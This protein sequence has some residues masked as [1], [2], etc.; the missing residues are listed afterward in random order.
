MREIS[1][2]RKNSTVPVAV[3]GFGTVGRSVAR[4]LDGNAGHNLQ[5]S[6]I[7]TR[8]GAAKRPPWL[9]PSVRFTDSF[10]EVLASGA[11]I[12]VELIG[13]VNPAR[14]WIEKALH[15][16][17]SVVTANKEVIA[18][19]GEHLAEL[20]RSR[21]SQLRF[22]GA[23][24]GVIPVIAA[25]Q[26]G[27]A[28]DRAARIAGILNGTCNHV[29][30]RMETEELPFEDALEE[31]RKLGFAEADPSRD[32]DG[33]DAAAKLAILVALAFGCRIDPSQIAR[34]PVSAVSVG[35]F[36]HA[37]TLGCTI[38]QVSWADREK[39]DG[40]VRAGVFPALVPLG[41]AFGQARESRNVVSITGELGGEVSLAGAGAGGDATAVAVVSDILAIAGNGSR[42]AAQYAPNGPAVV[43]DCIFARWHLRLG[44][45]DDPPVVRSVCGPRPSS[46]LEQPMQQLT[47]ARRSAGGG[48]AKLPPLA[49]PVL[50]LS[51]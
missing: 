11:S 21:S 44:G 40:T 4:M 13:G 43:D 37:R 51:P 23:V 26:E 25:I 28:A 48:T 19:D 35:D 16:G 12:I 47:K 17:R 32:I 30:S 45:E 33:R 36:A 5:L 10:D 20:A 39:E 49:L 34:A 38:R 9:P 29:L 6:M 14:E 24:G 27:L 41:S 8:G 46:D 18:E 31:A 22:G 15:S 50:D 7:C 3:I 42:P 2:G 1:N